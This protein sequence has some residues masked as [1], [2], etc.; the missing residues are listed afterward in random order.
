MNSMFKPIALLSFLLMFGNTHAQKSSAEEWKNEIRKV[1]HLVDQEIFTPRQ[2]ELALKEIKEAART[3]LERQLLGNGNDDERHYLVI[4]WGKTSENGKIMMIHDTVAE[5]NIQSQLNFYFNNVESGYV[6]RK[7]F[8]KPSQDKTVQEKSYTAI[9]QSNPPVF[10]NKYFVEI[11]SKGKVKGR[12]HKI[13]VSRLTN[14]DGL[15]QLTDSLETAVKSELGSDVKNIKLTTE[16]DTQFTIFGADIPERYMND[17]ALYAVAIKAFGKGYKGWI[18]RRDFS[19]TN[20]GVYAVTLAEADSILKTYIDNVR[21]E[22]NEQGGKPKNREISGILHVKEALVEPAEGSDLSTLF[23]EAG[24]LQAFNYPSRRLKS[25]KDLRADL[26][27]D[28]ANQIHSEYKDDISRQ[29]EKALGD[30]DN[31]LLDLDET[32]KV[33][34]DN[35]YY[36]VLSIEK[37]KKDSPTSVYF[38]MGTGFSQL[39]LK[40]NGQAFAENDQRLFNISGHIGLRGELNLSKRWYL[41]SEVRYSTYRHRFRRN[42]YFT[43]VDDE[44]AF[45]R[46]EESLDRS[47]FASSYFDLQLGIGFRNRGGFLADAFEIG[48]YGG[49]HTRSTSRNRFKDEDGYT[50]RELQRGSFDVN[51]YRLGFY[52]SFS[53]DDVIHNRFMFDTN[54]YFSN[55]DGPD[56]QIISYALMVCF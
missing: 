47:S 4:F 17:P 56:L 28:L 24:E 19:V 32:L 14:A 31:A 40:S 25:K 36:S 3:D 5:G 49:A 23:Q 53:L 8:Y 52:V 9:H 38:L 27:D 44:T 51:P 22:L 39:A 16:V 54:S 45:I 13:S 20:G 55:W 7:V 33:F 26:G 48:V 6:K 37:R 41:S 12:S 11:S 43:V 34:D 21:K 30:I 42:N 46:S 50:I 1:Y 29:V 18:I 15:A 2:G 35:E 10:D